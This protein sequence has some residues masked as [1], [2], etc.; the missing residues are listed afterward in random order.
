MY[1]FDFFAL[2]PKTFALSSQ[3][4]LL[5]QL[6]TVIANFV[7]VLHLYCRP[8]WKRYQEYCYETCPQIIMDRSL[9]R[10]LSNIRFLAITRSW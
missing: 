6:A 1:S 7:G 4:T 8:P 2:L 3:K 5:L 10:S 9:Q